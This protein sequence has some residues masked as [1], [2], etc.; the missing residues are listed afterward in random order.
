MCCITAVYLVRFSGGGYSV[1]DTGT[2]D[3]V[4]VTGHKVQVRGQASSIFSW[5][6]EV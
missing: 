6:Q 4:W 2:R 5:I 3:R 1:Q